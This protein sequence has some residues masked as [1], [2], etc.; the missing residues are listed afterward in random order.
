[1]R[2]RHSPDTAREGVQPGPR[3][4]GSGY[5]PELVARQTMLVLCNP[6]S[7]RCWLGG[8]YRRSDLHMGQLVPEKNCSQKED[9]EAMKYVVCTTGSDGSWYIMVPA[10]MSWSASLTLE[11]IGQRQSRVAALSSGF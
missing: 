6:Q 1:V 2:I 7:Q 8:H 5:T 4:S 10:V 3:D 11:H 9:K